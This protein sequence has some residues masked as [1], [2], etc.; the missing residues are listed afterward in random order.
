MMDPELSDPRSP[1]FHVKRFLDERGASLAGARVLDVPAGAGTTTQILLD[2]GAIVEAFDIFPEYFMVDGARCTYANVLR[3]IPVSDGYADMVVC[4]EGIEHFCDQIAALREFNRV[5]KVG[6]EP[7]L[8]TPSYSHLVARC[9]YLLFE[10]ESLRRMP[11]NERDDVWMADTDS[12]GEVYFGHL[13]L[14]G[15]QRLRTMARLCGFRVT[16]VRWVRLSK[17]SLLLLPFL[18]PPLA[19]SSLWRYHRNSRRKSAAGRIAIY[20]EQVTLNLSLRTLLNRHMF[21]VL[22]KDVSTFDMDLSYGIDMR[23]LPKR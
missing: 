13:F 15:M 18:Y 7:V 6:G 3:G 8:T 22:Q 23:A 21:V 5:L 19:L 16:E 17:M 2:H 9:S 10:S 1:K 11:P 20:K 12:S 4:Q 14:I